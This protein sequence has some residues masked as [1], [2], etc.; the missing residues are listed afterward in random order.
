MHP[1]L[2]PFSPAPAAIFSEINLAMSARATND[3]LARERWSIG[4]PYDG[5]EREVLL[6][7]PVA[8]GPQAAASSAAPTPAGKS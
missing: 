5:T 3:E 4:L 1:G 6:V 7:R 2:G 8:G